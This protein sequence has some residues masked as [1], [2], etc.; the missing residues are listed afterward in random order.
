MGNWLRTQL[1]NVQLP[2]PG[3][4]MPIFAII[5]H[6]LVNGSIQQAIDSAK[7]ARHYNLALLLSLYKAPAGHLVR[8]RSAQQVF[9]FGNF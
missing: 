3:T 7:R 4:T 9:E 5:F 2:P 8:Q 6:Y 1:A